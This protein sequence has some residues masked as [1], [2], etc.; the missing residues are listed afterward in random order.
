MQ[1]VVMRAGVCRL[2]CRRRSSRGSRAEAGRL[3]YIGCL[4][5]EEEVD[6]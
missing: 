3:L 4:A 6:N 5:M 2:R 1:R